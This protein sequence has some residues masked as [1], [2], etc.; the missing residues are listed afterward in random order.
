MMDLN[1][2]IEIENEKCRIYK[3]NFE[4]SMNYS[5]LVRYIKEKNFTDID[6][7]HLIINGT[8]YDYKN[9]DKIIYLKEGDKINIINGNI[10]EN[11]VFVEFHKNLNLNEYC[12]N[13]APLS[14]ILRLILI[15]HI[16]SYITDINKIKSNRIKKIISV[17]KKGIKLKE[18]A[19]NDIKINLEETSGRNILAYSN[20]VCSIMT[21]AKIKELLN[22]IASHEKND[23]I[24]Y[25]NILSIYE[26]LNQFFEKEILKALEKSYFE[27][28]IISLSMYE[29]ANRKRFLEK[30]KQC[31]N[32][33]IKY[34]FHGTQISPISKIL[35]KGFLY[36]MKTFYGIGVGFSDMLDYTLFFSGGNEFRNRRN[37][38]N[39]ILPVNKIFS[40]VATE[41]YYDKNKLKN[42]FDY[43]LFTG[44]FLHFPSY[45]ELKMEYPEKM[46]EKNGVHYI[47]VEPY[48]GQFR[49]NNEIIKDKKE[50]KFLGTEYIITEFDQMLP[51]Y[52]LTFK[53]DEY[54]IIWRD[55]HFN[56]ASKFHN[57]LEEK[58]LF[59]Y[60][61]SKFN[62]YCENS[63]EKALEIVK[64]K[65]YNKIILISNIGLDLSGKKFIEIAR[66][67]LG[68]NIPILFFSNNKN[69]LSWIQNF[70][71]ALFTDKDNFFYDYILNYNDKGLLDLKKRI[72]NYYNIKLKFDNDFLKFP[73]FI[74]KGNFS[75]FLFNEPI[76][77]FKKIIIKNTKN[78]CILCLDN[79]GKLIFKSIYELNIDSYI[80]YAT[81]KDDEI[82]LF[83][84][85]LYLG[86]NIESKIMTREKYMHV[87]KY[88]KINENGYIIYYYN[89]N[90]VFTMIGKYPVIEKENSDKSN[91]IFKFIEQYEES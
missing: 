11:G 20:Y 82:T 46:V 1:I 70:P 43:S 40:C 54:L 91:Q 74:N 36:P 22:L 72:E 60:E 47:R 48:K 5:E 83:S 87:F 66:T 18:T 39:K 9:E 84:N 52:G 34:L 21:D 50:G 28:S 81:F 29:Q 75:D 13:N 38:Y 35:T 68:F 26:E 64:R 15:K 56:K 3:A 10:K 24:N 30:M 27:Y 49:T 76:P 77:N 16:S 88:E 65:K 51:L 31:Q 67:I 59:I 17:L 61:Y 8:N 44:E 57:F 80:W 12:M 14:G 69:H 89:K 90:Y 79:Y 42:I 19:E 7:F 53:R 33:I 32:I 73:K 23:I 58:K 45:E 71:N 78:K 55:S 4:N 86:V 2:K 25:W 6:D 85:G 62:I 41:V 63:I 37:Y